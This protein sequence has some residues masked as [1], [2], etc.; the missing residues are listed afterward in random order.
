MPPHEYVLE[1]TQPTDE[2]EVLKDEP[3]ISAQFTYTAAVRKIDTNVEGG[4]APRG[5]G[6]QAVDAPQQCRL[7]GARKPEQNQHF[8]AVHVE[9]HILQRGG[10]P[11]RLRHVADADHHV[12]GVHRCGL[13]QPAHFSEPVTSHT[14]RTPS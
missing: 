3:D 12:T 6:M 2:V 14:W 1:A 8:T 9:V 11:E 13:H 7:P 5:D 4:D 10:R